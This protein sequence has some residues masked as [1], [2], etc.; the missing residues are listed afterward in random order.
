[1]DVSPTGP[2]AR[3]PAADKDADPPVAPEVV[4]PV[5]A[6]P[7]SSVT[8]LLAQL[9]YLALVL[10]ALYQVFV[11][12]QPRYKHALRLRG[13]DAGATAVTLALPDVRVVPIDRAI[14]LV[15]KPPRPGT[16]PAAPPIRR[17]L[18]RNHVPSGE[19]YHQLRELPKAEQ[20][21]LEV[22]QAAPGPQDPPSDTVVV[23]TGWTLEVNSTSDYSRQV[24]RRLLLFVPL[25]LVPLLL[26]RLL[27][28]LLRQ[29]R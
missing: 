16:P 27:R 22:I 7:L 5:R 3:P 1:M 19:I 4:A 15:P 20:V 13:P 23:H 21:S 8:R 28:A 24:G 25:L 9:S 2:S 6:N 29:R 17:V 11:A 12:P 18:V 14:M 26:S 10:F